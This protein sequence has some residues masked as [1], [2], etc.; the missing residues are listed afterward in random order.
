[1]T[2]LTLRRRS[3]QTAAELAGSTALWAFGGPMF[4][5]VAFWHVS[6][7]VGGLGQNG[8]IDAA[9]NFIQPSPH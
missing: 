9:V 7:S 8:E 1:M 6:F 5:V 3:E 2:V 4:T